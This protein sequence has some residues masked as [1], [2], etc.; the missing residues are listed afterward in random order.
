MNFAWR[1]MEHSEVDSNTNF[2][3]KTKGCTIPE[4]Q[5]FDKSIRKFVEMPRNVKLCENYNSSLLKSNRTHILIDYGNLI[6]FNISSSANVTCCYKSFYRPVSVADVFADD[7]DER[8]AYSDCFEFVDSI[9]ISDEFVKVSCV[10]EFIIFYEQFFAFTPKKYPQTNDGGDERNNPKFNVI[11]MGIDA[12]SRLNFHRTMPKTLA[13][14]KKKEAIELYG[15]NK[16]GDNTFPN[17]IPMLLGIRESDLKRTCWPD[18]KSTFDN[19]PFIWNSFKD[20]GYYT[21]FGEDSASLG[22]FNYEKFG[23]IRNPTDYYLHTFITEAEIYS[24]NNKDYNSYICMG[25]KYFYDVLLEYIESLTRALRSSKLFA[26]FWEVTMSHDFL[27]YP[28]L[29]DASYER[30]L[31][32]LDLSGYLDNTILIMLSDHGI[33]WGDIRF[34]KQGRLEERLPLIQVL[35]P[36]TFATTYPAAF[37]NIEINRHRLT[38]PFDIHATLIDLTNLESINNSNIRSRSL[39]P[40]SGD[41]GIS[42]FLPIPSNRTCKMAEID[43]HWCTCNRGNALSVQSSGATQAASY[44]LSHL[45]ALIAS[46]SQCAKLTLVNIVEITEMLVGTPYDKEIGWQEFLVVIRTAPGDGVFEGTV[47]QVN[48]EWS[49]SGSIS[50]LNLYGDQSHCEHNYQLKLY[51]Y[52]K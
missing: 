22:T 35:L 9:E 11:M 16:V 51:C 20:V 14:L 38:T 5:P 43:D 34:T 39:A 50:R 33:R 7:V 41:R 8:V 30:F 13:Y 32:Q 52:C 42:L 4:L 18:R 31:K 44:L 48:N 28:M 36:P 24:G 2:T 12:V 27:N 3:I 17:L 6:Y 25:N 49:L 40:Y 46:N 23:F 1:S 45:N 47:R 19:C 37:E 26:F 29:M 21:A 10:Y 15:Y